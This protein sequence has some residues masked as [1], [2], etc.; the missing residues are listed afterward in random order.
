MKVSGRT[1]AGRFL[2]LTKR[3]VLALLIA[4]GLSKSRFENIAKQQFDAVPAS[5]VQLPS[6]ISA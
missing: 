3:N 1:R 6:S 4:S 2:A 5:G